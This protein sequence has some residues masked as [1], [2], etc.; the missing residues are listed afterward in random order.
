MDK[1]N[2]TSGVST[3]VKDSKKMETQNLN[4]TP[5]PL[6]SFRG[7][8]R[9]VSITFTG[10]GR[11]LQQFKDES[12]INTI[13]GQYMRTGVLPSL[14]DPKSGQYIDATGFEYQAAMEL[15]ASAN[16]MFHNLPSALRARFNNNPADFLEFAENPDNQARLAELGVKRASA[17][18]AR[19]GEQQTQKVGDT[20]TPTAKTSP[21]PLPA[22]GEGSR[23]EGSQPA[24]PE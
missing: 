2:K 17:S 9:K 15:V 20:P 4:L 11:T 8:L 1:I 5:T 7:S 23:G 21:N 14:V 12:D 19:Y 3:P 16:S 18:E 6:H 24:K 13:M 22:S 10:P